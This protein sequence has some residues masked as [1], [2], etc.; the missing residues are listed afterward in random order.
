MAAFNRPLTLILLLSSTLTVGCA[1]QSTQPAEDPQRAQV[2]EA[3]KVTLPEC[4][5]FLAEL[6]NAIRDGEPRELNRSEMR[7]FESVSSRL[8]ELLAD[9]DSR[10]A[11]RHEDEVEFFN[12]HSQLEAVVVG[13]DR[14]QVLCRRRHKVGTNFKVTE[15]KSVADWRTEQEHAQRQLRSIFYAEPR[16]P[17]EPGLQ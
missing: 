4:R 2:I 17:P 14:D 9:F 1:T 11:M 16:I 12:L 7:E 15:C 3:E 6:D 8:D 13:R 10:E 5:E